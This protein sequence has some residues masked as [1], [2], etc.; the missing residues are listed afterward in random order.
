[1]AAL[2]KH[3]PKP[4]QPMSDLRP[5]RTSRST[6]GLRLGKLRSWQTAAN[7]RLQPG[8]HSG[9]YGNQEQAIPSRDSRQ[10]RLLG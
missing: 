4:V 8:H 10:K 7:Q 9:R 6:I 1:M 3:R 2:G 5:H